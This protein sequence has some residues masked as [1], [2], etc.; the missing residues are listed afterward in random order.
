MPLDKTVADYIHDNQTR[1]V[2]EI[3]RLASQPSVS[4][5]KEGIDECAALVESMLESIGAKTKLLQLPGAAPLVYGEI[6]SSRSSKT[7]LFYNHYDVQPEVPL[8]LWRSPPFKPEVREGRLYG[9]GVSDD[10][11]ELVSRLKLI[12]SYVEATG[13]PPCNVK[14]CFEGEEEVGSTHLE[15]YVNRDPDLFRSD[16]VIWEYGKI[17]GEGRAVVGLGVKGMIYLELTVRSLSQDAHSMYAA[18]LPS[19]VWRLN[20]LLSLIK[21]SNER[22]LIPGWYDKVQD[23]ADDELRLLEEQPSE[24][25]ELLS[26]YG[27]KD[28]AGGMSLAQAKKA[29]VARPTANVA[30][31]WAGYTGPGS[32]TVLPAEAHCKMDFRLVPNQEPDELYAKFVAYL[33]AN[34]FADVEIQRETMEPAAR[35]SYKSDLAQAA[36][37]GAKEVFQKD[38]I[39][40]LSSAGTGPLYIF[41]RRYKVA[42]LDIGISP[43]DSALHSPNE[44]IRL[45]YFERG[46]LWLGQTLENFLS[47]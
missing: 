28:F 23:L 43:V 31:I 4:A 37:K 40:E 39:I 20:R 8:E 38:P 16:A 36:I 6:A 41:T 35:T 5:R 15:E 21:D 7:V 10:K 24:A 46:M 18:A 34:G 45:D 25:K 12:E 29:L 47:K 2:K 17:D 22:I 42:G 3:V 13:E 32:K 27:S 33:N 9:R 19:A 14:F 44:N 1:F 26:T 11:G 30:G